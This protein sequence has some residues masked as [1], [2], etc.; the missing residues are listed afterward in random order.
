MSRSMKRGFTLTEL[1]VVIAIIGVLVSLL[2]PAV[3]MAREAARKATCTNNLRQLATAFAGFTAAKDRFPGSQEALFPTATGAAAPIQEIQRWAPWFVLLTPYFDQKP[4]WDS[5]NNP[6]IPAAALPVQFVGSLW[7]P[8]AGSVDIGTPAN[9]YLCNAGFYP[10]PGIDTAFSSA[11]ATFTAPFTFQLIQRKANCVFTDRANFINQVSPNVLALKRT[12][13]D[14][15]DGASNTALFSE[16]LTAANW[17]VILPPPPAAFGFPMG[18]TNTNPPLLSNIMVW[19]HVA[20]TGRPVNNNPILNPPAQITPGTLQLWMK[21]N[22]ELG[23]A[24]PGHS[25]ETW[26][27]TSRHPGGVIMS[28]V[29]GSTKYVSQNIP[30]HV[31]QS[32]LTPENR[33]SDMPENSYMMT[34]A[35]TD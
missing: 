34:L 13:S 33:R 10:R 17:N 9:S 22:R 4:V 5:W 8:S 26:H 1:L 30:Y 20:E 2:L 16:S 21:I 29:D 7:C 15:A 25:A 32:L 23:P 27:P 6:T 3:Q 14:I 19:L 11:G 24:T 31:Y 18:G 28:F 35:E 12:L